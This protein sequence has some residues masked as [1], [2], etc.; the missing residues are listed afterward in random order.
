MMHDFDSVNVH[1]IWIYLTKQ[2]HSTVKLPS[3]PTLPT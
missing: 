2:T 1:M 3:I